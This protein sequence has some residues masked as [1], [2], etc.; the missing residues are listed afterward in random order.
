MAIFTDVSTPATALDAIFTVKTLGV[1]HGW[2][3]SAS[4]DGTSY[5]AASDVITTSANLSAVGSWFRLKMPGTTRELLFVMK[6][7]NTGWTIRYC[8]AGFLTGAPSATV[9]PTGTGSQVLFDGTFFGTD[10]T[11]RW[12]VSFDDASPYEFWAASLTIGSLAAST[13]IALLAMETGSYDATDLD[14]YVIYATFTFTF[15]WTELYQT[16]TGSKN[17]RSWYR[18]APSLVGSTWATAAFAVPWIGTANVGGQ[19]SA[20]NRGSL[21]SV[22]S[23]EVPL[24]ILCGFRMTVSGIKGRVR[25]AKYVASTTG[26]APNGTHLT[27]GNTAY[28]VRVGD[29]WLQ[30]DVSVPSL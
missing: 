23:Q 15:A 14:P 2:T 29:L 12:L 7:A 16:Y 28:W 5:G 8:V 24:D 4:G 13:A 26:A 27:D 19:E 22:D 6:T 25:G 3:V 18:Y 11:Y 9:A 1:A 10:G 20:V 21:S 17:F 30:W